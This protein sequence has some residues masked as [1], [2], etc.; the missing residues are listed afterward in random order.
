MMNACEYV[1]YDGL[2]L[3]EL[4]QRGDISRQ[5]LAD[6]ALGVMETLNPVVN[7]VIEIYPTAAQANMNAAPS[8]LFNGVPFL[9]KDIGSH[10]ADVTFELG[11]RLTKGL[12]A[13]PFASELI[14][15]FRQSGV[16]ILG[17]TNVPE[18]GSSCTTEPLLHGPTRNP[19]NLTRTAGGS[20]G[21]A[22]AAVASGMVP[23]AHANDAGGSIRWPAACC[24]LFGL[25]PSRNLN[26]HGPDTA[27]ALNGLAAEHIISRSVRD[28]A[29]ML[30]YTAGP[31]TGAWCYT[32]R[33]EGSY[34][35]AL[36][37]PP[38]PLR[39]GINL[40]PIFPPTTLQAEVITAVRDTAKLCESLGH[41]VEEAS[42]TFDHETLL[43]AFAI[44]W[45][46][47]L[48]A[49]VETLSTLTGNAIDQHHLEAHV[50]LAY[51]DAGQVSASQLLWALE[52][53]NIAARAYGVFF[54]N[55][56]VM[57]T[58][59]GSMEPFDIGKIGKISTPS[60][61]E[62]F[63]EMCSHCPFL[64]TANIA[65]IPAMSVPLH[66]SISGL[67]VGSHF[68]AKMGDEKLLLQLA[69]QLETARPWAKKIPAHH[70]SNYR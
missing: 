48:R 57:L 69:A 15:R 68:L 39:I 33:Y 9:L 43:R 59:T 5:E 41:Y 2:G 3:G 32:P 46:C 52:Q 8:A 29:A 64:S 54:Q 28:T 36:N 21:G 40:N 31:D 17:R 35:Q 16:T 25:K 37:T 44:I 20:S 65:G 11:S 26:P 58:P 27:L 24:G 4:I 61:F 50:L 51:R 42:F 49:G 23:L 18:M 19:W 38:K 47:N 70:I 12:K 1:S 10:D 55:Y 30:D 22:A 13:P 6:V 67:P 63:I 66:W 7:A 45:S 34:L 53:M 56:D 14:N 62:W 60:F